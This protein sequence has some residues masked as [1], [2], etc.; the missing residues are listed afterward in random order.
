MSH[1]VLSINIYLYSRN[2]KYVPSGDGYFCRTAHTTHDSAT[3]L[4]PSLDV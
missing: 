2:P 3:F 4:F 1:Q